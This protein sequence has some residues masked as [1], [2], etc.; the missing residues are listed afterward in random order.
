MS[1]D[2]MYDFLKDKTLKDT[3]KEA[4]R[5]DNCG[6]LKDFVVKF[7]ADALCKKLM[8]AD[9]MTSLMVA[10][11]YGATV[12]MR[13]L[14]ENGADV[15]AVDEH[16]RD[17]AFHATTEDHGQAIC[18]LNEMGADLERFNP[19]NNMNPILATVLYGNVNAFCAL[20]QCGVS[21]D[22]ATMDH[23]PLHFDDLVRTSPGDVLMPRYKEHLQQLQKEKEYATIQASM[24]I[25]TPVS[26]KKFRPR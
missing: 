22:V 17:A 8:F 4:I 14:I 2:N 18:L 12:S 24:R 15:H 5:T 21:T 11:Q 26:I 20:L 16:H 7:G 13:Y 10:A 9:G 23:N 25:P 19:G 1:S 3:L 6:F